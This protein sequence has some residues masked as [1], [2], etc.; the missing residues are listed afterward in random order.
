MRQPSARSSTQRTTATRRRPSGP[1]RAEGTEIAGGAAH[2]SLELSPVAPSTSSEFPWTGR[3]TAAQRLMND[4]SDQASRTRSR[5]VWLR[6]RPTAAGGEHSTQPTSLD[7]LRQVDQTGESGSK[8]AGVVVE[9]SEVVVEVDV[10]P[11]AACV[12]RVGGRSPNQLSSDTGASMIRTHLGIEEE[13]VIAAVPCD[14]HEADER[15]VPGPGGYPAKAVRSDCVPP[16]DRSPP[17]IGQR[18]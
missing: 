18:Q 14:I 17:A 15:S 11:L 1:K 5:P 10:E 7:G 12:F 16:S 13:R 3:S 4:A 2:A 8:P 6:P 9:R